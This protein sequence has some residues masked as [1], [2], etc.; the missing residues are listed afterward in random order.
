VKSGAN[1]EAAK[2]VGLIIAERARPSK[3]GMVFDAAG[4]S[5]HGRVESAGRGRA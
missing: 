4:I 1:T 2:Q 5:Y 3:G